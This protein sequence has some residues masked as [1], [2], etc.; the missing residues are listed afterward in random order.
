MYSYH[1]RIRQRINNGE[2]VGIKKGRGEFAFVLLFSTYPYERPIRE[3]AAF[4]YEKEL[5]EFSFDFHS[6]RENSTIIGN[7]KKTD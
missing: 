3:H 2:M 5:S 4:R 7:H 1:N 6:A